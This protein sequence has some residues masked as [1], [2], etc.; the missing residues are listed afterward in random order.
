MTEIRSLR[1]ARGACGSGES[2]AA[3]VYRA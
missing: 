3:A 1:K 2:A